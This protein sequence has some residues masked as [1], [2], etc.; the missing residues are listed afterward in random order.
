MFGFVIAI[1]AGFVTPMIETPLAR[2]V[3]RALE[4]KINLENDELR[5][6]AFMLALIIAG[7]ICAV[8]HAGS[9]LSLALGG[10]LGYFGARIVEYVKSLT[11]K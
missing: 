2:P 8:L 9:P 7:L 4:G 1:I 5:L 11:K 10:T 6:L 3:A